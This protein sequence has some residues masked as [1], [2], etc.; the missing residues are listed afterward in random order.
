M[1]MTI[2]TTYSTPGCALTIA[3]QMT[4][5]SQTDC[6]DYDIDTIGYAVCRFLRNNER[7][8]SKYVTMSYRMRFAKGKARKPKRCCFFAPAKLLELPGET[9]RVVLSVDPD[10]VTVECVSLYETYRAVS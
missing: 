8:C 2:G 7:A 9:V 10:G 1:K 5:A 4:F 6:G 3:P